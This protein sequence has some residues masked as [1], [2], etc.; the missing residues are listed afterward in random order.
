[1]PSYYFSKDEF[2]NLHLNS[3]CQCGNWLIK[4]FQNPR[5]ILHKAFDYEK[6]L[7]LSSQISSKSLVHI[8]YSKLS[9][10]LMWI[11]W[12]WPCAMCSTGCSLELFST[13]MLESVPLFIEVCLQVSQRWTY[14]LSCMRCHFISYVLFHLQPLSGPS[15]AL[16]FDCLWLL[17][18]ILY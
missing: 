13:A 3:K 11:P 18:I 16:L 4:Q 7:L 10:L 17:R 14:T 6:L 8:Y 9:D 2:N 12:E 15:A 5:N 1:M